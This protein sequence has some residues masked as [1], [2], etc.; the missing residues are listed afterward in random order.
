MEG[1]KVVKEEEQ[2]EEAERHPRREKER[3]REASETQRRR[4]ARRGAG[5]SAPRE[6]SEEEGFQSEGAHFSAPSLLPLA[7]GT[8]GEEEDREKEEEKVFGAE[9]IAAD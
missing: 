8:K 1:A 3:A 7:E 2:Q 4:R 9:P 5:A 6:I